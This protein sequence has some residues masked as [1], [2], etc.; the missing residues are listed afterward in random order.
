MGHQASAVNGKNGRHPEPLADVAS[1]FGHHLATLVDLQMQ[2]LSEDFKEASSA[3][4]KPVK[5][6]VIAALIAL[7]AMVLLEFG[8]A[9]ILY[10][11][12]PLMRCWAYVIV[13]VVL[14]AI[15]GIIVAVAA[16]SAKRAP[17]PFQRSQQEFL[18]NIRAVNALWRRQQARP[19]S[20]A[21]R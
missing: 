5:A 12:T 1:D 17:K 21:V 9:E 8:L 11:Y 4:L 20:S 15:A 7:P 10:Q 14:M 6:A 18:N 2:L 13:A 3:A 16:R 19:E